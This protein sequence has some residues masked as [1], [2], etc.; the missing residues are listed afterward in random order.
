LGSD[1]V[2]HS[3]RNVQVPNSCTKYFNFILAGLRKYTYFVSPPLTMKEEQR[4]SV[5]KSGVP[6]K[7]FGTRRM[8]MTAR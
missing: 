5:L 1:R 8:K 6:R 3:E 4:L 2:E 7:I